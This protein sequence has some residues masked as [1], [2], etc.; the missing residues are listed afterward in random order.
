[1]MNL[2]SKVPPPLPSSWVGA[3]LQVLHFLSRGVKQKQSL[4]FPVG[5]WLVLE[6]GS[7]ELTGTPQ[8]ESSFTCKDQDQTLFYLPF[9]P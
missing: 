2:Q 6:R 7:S 5:I 1:M 9:I 4:L 8:S 3:G